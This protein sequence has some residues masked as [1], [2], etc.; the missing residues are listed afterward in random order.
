MEID[1]EKVP[2]DGGGIWVP[3]RRT[4]RQRDAPRGSASFS[5]QHPIARVETGCPGEGQQT[6]SPPLSFSEY[7]ASCQ[8]QIFQKTKR[9]RSS[10]GRG[11]SG[12]P[13]SPGLCLLLLPC[14]ML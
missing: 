13:R 10:D 4:W 11:W 14:L 2:E 5:Q 1:S 3:E 8:S 12:P 9:F 6:G 7:G